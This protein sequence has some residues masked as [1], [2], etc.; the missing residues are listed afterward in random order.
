MNRR[1]IGRIHHNG[2]GVSAFWHSVA[3]QI[4]SRSACRYRPLSRILITMKASK[5]TITQLRERKERSEKFAMLTCYDYPTAQLM[6]EAGV[7]TILVGDTHA[8]VC[9]GHASTLPAGMDM[10]VEITK[11]VRKGAPEAFLIG[12]M[13]FLSYQAS[14][15]EAV[16]NAGR[17]M[18]E[19]GCDAVKIEVDQRFVSTIEAMTRAAIP[20]VAHLGL[21]PQSVNQI[22]GYKCQGK[23]ADSAMRLVEDADLLEKAGACMLLLEAVPME[24]AGIITRRAAV[25]VIGCVAGPYCD[26]T[27]VVLHDMLGYKAGHPPKSIKRYADLRAVLTDAFTRYKGDIKTGEFPTAAHSIQMPKNEL[28][29]LERRLE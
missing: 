14:D 22:G 6:A 24:L 4:K 1:V 23:S 9:L 8:E 12:D 10:M 11:A 20:V 13:P 26:G 15:I 2:E 27:V 29:M 21:K 5:I 16:K 7:D 17:F 19:A 18:A 3:T 28:E 25:P